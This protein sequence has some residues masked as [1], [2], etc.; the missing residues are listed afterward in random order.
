MLIRCLALKDFR[1]LAIAQIVLFI[2][3]IIYMH[4]VSLLIFFFSNKQYF[5]YIIQLLVLKKY[6]FSNKCCSLTF[7]YHQ[8]LYLSFHTVC[9]P[10]FNIKKCL[11]STKSALLE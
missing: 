1:F 8:R 2:L 5:K 11:L 3:A 10:V 7:V 4:L 9:S 6:L